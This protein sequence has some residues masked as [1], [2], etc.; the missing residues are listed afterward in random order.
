M[1][2]SGYKRPI[3]PKTHL[4][5]LV[6]SALSFVLSE[7]FKEV[8]KTFSYLFLMIKKKRLFI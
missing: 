5:G 8:G 6:G 3:T 4:K 1:L 7:P 2:H